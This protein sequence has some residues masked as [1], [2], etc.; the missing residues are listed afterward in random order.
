MERELLARSHSPGFSILTLI[1]YGIYVG[2]PED[3]IIHRKGIKGRILYPTKGLGEK[4]AE[5]K[6]IV[7]AYL[8]N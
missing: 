2:D 5:V 8:K 7:D 6:F 4:L 1:F 3:L